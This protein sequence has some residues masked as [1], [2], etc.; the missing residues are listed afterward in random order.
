MTSRKL[1][2]AMLFKKYISNPKKSILKRTVI[3]LN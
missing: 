1:V 3:I 2:N